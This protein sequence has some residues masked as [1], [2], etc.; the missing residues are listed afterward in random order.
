MYQENTSGLYITMGTILRLFANYSPL[1]YLGSGQKFSEKLHVG[2]ILE[3]GGYGRFNIGVEAGMKFSG[4]EL[5]L[6]SRG[7]GGMI[8]PKSAGSNSAF[9]SLKKRI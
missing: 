7:L 4:F 6:G 2:G 8:F 5:L 1:I 9:I 3:F